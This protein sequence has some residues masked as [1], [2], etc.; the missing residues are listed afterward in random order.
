MFFVISQYDNDANLGYVR[1]A[2]GSS[3]DFWEASDYR[4]KENAVLLTEALDDLNQLKPI[5]YNWIEEP[6]E[7]D[8]GFIAHEVGKLIPNAVIGE[9]DAV[10]KDGSIDPQ[11]LQRGEIIPYL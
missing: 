8:V 3:V 11:F 2:N 6:D 10:N 7:I 4:L 9:K 5:H 1:S